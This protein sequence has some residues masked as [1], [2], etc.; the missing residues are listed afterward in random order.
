MPSYNE[1]LIKLAETKGEQLIDVQKYFEMST[2]GLFFDETHFTDP[3]MAE[4]ARFLVRE[5]DARGLLQTDQG[6]SSA[7]ASE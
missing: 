7:G 1:A 4:M 2:E 3:G 6:N 5:F